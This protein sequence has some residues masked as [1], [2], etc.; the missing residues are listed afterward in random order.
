[1]NFEFDPVSRYVSL[2]KCTVELLNQALY[3]PQEVNQR[4]FTGYR[5]QCHCP[6]EKARQVT[7]TNF[8]PRKLQNLALGTQETQNLIVATSSHDTAC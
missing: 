8:T 1:M 5:L 6:C 4:L 2:P 3:L 7:N